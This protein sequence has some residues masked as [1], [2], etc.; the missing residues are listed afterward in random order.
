MKVGF[1]CDSFSL[2]G[3]TVATLAYAQAWKT[4]GHESVVIKCDGQTPW[5]L[6]QEPSE[7]A[8]GLE[9][10]R[11]KEPEQLNSLIQTAGIEALYVLTAGQRQA[12][13]DNLDAQLWVH[14]VFPAK[15]SDIHGDRFTCISNWLTKE[16]Y[17]NLVPFVPHS[18]DHLI[19]EEARQPWRQEHGIPADAIVIGSMGGNHT[20][21]LDIA[22][23]GLKRALEKNSHL[24]FAALN[25]KPFL[26]HERALFL[27]GTNNLSIKSAFISG[28]DCMLHGRTQGET[29]GLACAEF[30]AAGKPV[31]AW[32]DAPERHHLEQFSPPSLQYSNESALFEMLNEFD[33][34]CW[35]SA[36]LQ[37][38]CEPFRAAAIATRFEQVFTSNKIR[39]SAI[40]FSSID[41]ALILKRRLHRSLR[42]RISQRHI[43]ECDLCHNAIDQA[44]GFPV[45]G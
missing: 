34:R 2:R 8:R 25:H 17:N 1:H 30:T 10:F 12:R 37:R 23:N 29:F 19:N 16:C 42:A 4:L 6:E 33:P 9:I 15:I 27:P 38:K 45:E 40:D 32:S 22:R 18:V 28:C 24:Y 39:V 20:F 3:V 43:Q 13:F 41:R 11:Y 21:D 5:I 14:A 26:Q 44:S 35:D 36:D 31:L 7:Q